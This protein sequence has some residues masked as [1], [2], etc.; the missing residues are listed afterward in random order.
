MDRRIPD[1]LGDSQRKSRLPWQAKNGA[2]EARAA[3]S[4]LVED[5]WEG[6]RKGG[7]GGASVGAVLTRQVELGQRKS[8]SVG[9]ECLGAQ[10]RVETRKDGQVYACED[11]KA[12]HGGK[13]QG[14]L[15]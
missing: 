9:T 5:N 12:A 6:S 15:Q 3:R 1:C 11:V 10:P 8:H 14:G 4:E 13:G 7:W 2:Q